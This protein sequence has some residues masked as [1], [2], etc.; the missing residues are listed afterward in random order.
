MSV[1]AIAIFLFALRG[2]SSLRYADDSPYGLPRDTEPLAYGLRLAPRYDPA[3]NQYTFGGQVEIWVHVNSITANVT[4]H[5][6]DLEIKSVAIVE[7]KTQTSVAVDGNEMDASAERLVIYAGSS[8]LPGRVY[9]V[10]IVFQGL[11]RTDMTGFYRS[12]YT[13]NGERK[14]VAQWFPNLGSRPELGW[15]RSF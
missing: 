11:L 8:L 7:S 14:Y 12:L 4:L 5:A 2:A 15:Q 1:R 13:E 3:E 10:R 6:R 9:Q